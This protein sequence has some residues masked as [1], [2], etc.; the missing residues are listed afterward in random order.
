MGN[1]G[2]WRTSDPRGSEV[3]K[4]REKPPPK[5]LLGFPCRWTTTSINLIQ[6]EEKTCFKPLQ[7]EA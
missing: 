5:D 3:K 1:L 7:M 4:F 6:S 2:S